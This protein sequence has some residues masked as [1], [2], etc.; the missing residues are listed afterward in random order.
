MALPG[1]WKEVLWVYPR[2]EDCFILGWEESVSD[3]REGQILR[4]FLGGKGS[5]S[6]PL[7]ILSVS[8][9]G[10]VCALL[11]GGV[12]CLVCLLGRR[13]GSGYPPLQQL[14]SA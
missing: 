8:E 7:V 14:L 4:L 6:I 13:E 2:G 1:V 11:P 5:V 12:V 10:R 3:F 9:W